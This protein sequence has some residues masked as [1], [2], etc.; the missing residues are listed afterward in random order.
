M[1]LFAIFVFNS[2][3]FLLHGLVLD[4]VSVVVAV[5]R[6]TEY[7]GF[8][9]DNPFKKQR[10]LQDLIHLILASFSPPNKRR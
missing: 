9:Y 7:A 6:V 1:F 8:A 4:V 5:A 3:L 10:E 2:L